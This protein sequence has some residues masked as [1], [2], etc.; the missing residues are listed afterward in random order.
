[1]LFSTALYADA[2]LYF[3][4]AYANIS[5]KFDNLNAK[6]SSDAIKVKVGYGIREAY[7]IEFSVENVKNESKIFSTK[8]DD[9]YG[10]NI[11][12]IKAF[13]LD[14]FIYPYFKAGF[15]AGRMDINRELQD[16]LN[17][18]SFNFELGTF[19]AVNEHLDFELG[20]GYKKI[21]YESI[22]TVVAETEYKS[23]AGTL[24][25]GFNTRF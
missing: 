15:G 22:D 5:E 3:G 20:Y 6:S 7:A 24:Y 2:K 21:S 9:K 13:D 14:T 11:E 4:V 17:Y 16:K 8:D 19:I 12:L 18:G 25:I 23:T 10:A 1:M